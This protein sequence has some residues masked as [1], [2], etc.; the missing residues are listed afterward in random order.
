MGVEIMSDGLAWAIIILVPTAFILIIVYAVNKSSKDKIIVSEASKNLFAT[1]D[2]VIVLS[3]NII[4]GIF[5]Y[6]A[7][8]NKN[9]KLV[10]Q[11]YNTAIKYIDY[12]KIVG[13]ELIEDGST[14]LSFGNII[15]GSILAGEAGA[16]I[17][18]MNRKDTVSNLSIKISLN[19]FNTPSYEL[20]MFTGVKVKKSEKV[21]IESI[22]HSNE[23][24][25][26]IKYII[27]NKQKI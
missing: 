27:N 17:G 3:E 9:R 22:K 10:I 23:I 26:T 24:I 15:G 4:N 19:D 20:I 5:T 16:I 6:V 25:D 11:L 21:Y 14:S 1:Y 7:F 13:V 8:D 18:G 12:D 2:K